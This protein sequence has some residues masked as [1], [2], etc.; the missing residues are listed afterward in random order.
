MSKLVQV[1][2]VCFCLGAML[3]ASASAGSLE[4]TLKANKV[5]CT[6]E[7]EEQL[8]PATDVKVG[9]T[10]EYEA[11]YRNHSGISILDFSPVFTVP[12]GMRY[13]PANSAQSVISV[14]TDGVSWVLADAPELPAAG[15]IRFLKLRMG[16]LRTGEEAAVRF[17]LQWR[18]KRKM[19]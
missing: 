15:E 5:V 10:V 3:A 19:V 13:D 8:R 16:D 17:R 1:A 4:S 7:G 12:A 2:G 9:D 18:P 14:S 11:V 6:E